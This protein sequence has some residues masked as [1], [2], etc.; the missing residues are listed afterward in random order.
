LQGQGG[1]GNAWINGTYY[2]GGGGGGQDY[3]FANLSPS[4]GGLGGGGRGSGERP[5]GTTF[6]ALAGNVNTGGGGGA[7]SHP[8]GGAN[9]GKAGGS[10]VVIFAHPTAYT[11][12]SNITGSNTITTSGGYVYYTFTGP[13]TIGFTGV[14]T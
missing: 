6:V 4:P 7:G 8:A 2:A 3:N 1:D 10:G 11:A 5:P 14:S 12:T 9:E 13:G